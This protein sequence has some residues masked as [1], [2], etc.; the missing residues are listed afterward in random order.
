MNS[1]PLVGPLEFLSGRE[2]RQW[3]RAERRALRD[4]DAEQL[5]TLR[6]L[7]ATG[8]GLTGLLYRDS[9]GHTAPTEFVIA[10]KRIRAE[11]VHVPALR[12]LTQA[13]AVMPAVPLLAASRY[14][15]FWV[16]TFQLPTA[17]VAV[18]ADALTILPDQHGGP[19]W[20][21]TLTP[22]VGVRRQPA[23]PDRWAYFCRRYPAAWSAA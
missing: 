1:N 15:P 2:R 7:A 8:G 21:A 16:L 12:A 5:A 9:G 20:P 14:R 3:R 4:H 6:N 19:T 11:R 13:L 23:H 10:G 22:P 18:L 17:P